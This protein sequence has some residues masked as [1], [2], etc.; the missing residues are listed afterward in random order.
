MVAL[1]A[2]LV[3]VSAQEGS[4]KTLKFSGYTWEVREQ[5]KSGPG[6]NYWDARNVW[7]D[8][9]GNLHLKITRVKGANGDEWHCAE[10]TSTEKF[11]FG[12]YEFQTLGRVDRFDQNIVLGLFDYPTYGEDPD[13]TNEID[14]EFARWG[15]AKYP[16][17][18]FTIYPAEGKRGTKDSF[19]FEYALPATTPNPLATHRFTRTRKQVELLTFNG[20][21]RAGDKPLA[22]WT[23]APAEARLIPQK[24]LATHLNLWLFQG[25]PPMDG[26]EV[27]VVLKKFSFTPM[28]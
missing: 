8:R 3:P 15:N 17:G 18:N 9:D 25:K 26:K 22:R 14:I 11:G 19:T 10:L 13:G 20:A 5:G 12:R 7:V 2:L 23:Y 27:E 1:C 28:R 16:N 6:P 24:P 21:G 4:I